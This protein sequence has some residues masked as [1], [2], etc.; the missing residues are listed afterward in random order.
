MADYA[1]TMPRMM[2]RREEDIV[3]EALRVFAQQSSSRINFAEQWEEVARLVIPAY[4]NTF[5][6][7]SFNTPGQKKT[8]LQVDSTGQSSLN[9]FAAICDSLLTPR[10]MRWHQLPPRTGDLLEARRAG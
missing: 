4:S 9:R 8:E 10:N 5:Q 6:Y 2:S 3:E 7:A 1:T